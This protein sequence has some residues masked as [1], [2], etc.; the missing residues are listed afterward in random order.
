MSYRAF[1]VNKVGDAFSAAPAELDESQLPAGD[2]TVQVEWSGLNY[3]DGL[4]CTPNGRI[5]RDYPMVPGIDFAGRVL[6]S[7]D[8]RFKEGA[9]VLMTG[10]EAGVSHPGGFAE[11]ARVPGDWLVPL[12]PGL[13]TKEAMALGTA[14]FTAALSVHALERHG[15]TP[16]AGPVIVTGATGGVGST[17]IGML[18]RLGY[19]VA[20]GTG[21]ASEHDFL[22][23]LG[24]REILS[25]EEVSAESERGLE[26]ERWAGA[27]DP[28]GGKTT[29]YLLRTM[30]YGGVV[31]VSGLTG[32]TVVNTS[33]L[34]FILRAVSLIGIESVFAPMALRLEL[35]RRLGGDLKPS[36]LL[37][38]IA[39]E[40]TLDGLNEAVAKILKG[41]MRGRTLIRL[42]G[43]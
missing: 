31:A 11:R 43:D 5:I 40:I 23:Q 9:A 25:R 42:A 18:A 22:R 30:R 13:T 10:F 39:R 32:G 33:V 24:A 15:L 36:G 8:A 21:K 7:R 19:T 12:P 26:K 34:P 41:E 20:A 27:V 29:A 1:V 16:A 4:A 14:G 6:A 38:L 3:K 2:V 28:V 35:W 17:A 37:D